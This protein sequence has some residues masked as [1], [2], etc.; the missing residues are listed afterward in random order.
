LVNDGTD[1]AIV[2]IGTQT[3]ATVNYNGTG[4]TNYDDAS[5]N[6][7]YGKLYTLSE[8]KAVSLPTGWRLP[9]K[10][11][12]ET[13][14]LFLGATKDN[15]GYVE[16]EATVSSKLKSKSDWTLT[17]GT[18]TSGFNAY[19]AGQ[20]NDGTTYDSKGTLATFWTSTGVIGDAKCQY[21]F[22]A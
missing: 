20:S 3:W 5:N 16:G 9:T 7:T 8:A 18:N 14:L 19:P 21:V 13:L 1:Y 15:D 4:G 6:P 2:K 12:A 11:D 10:A 17:Q 22:G